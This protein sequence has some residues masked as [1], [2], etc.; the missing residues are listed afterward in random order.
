MP[1]EGDHP[2]Q[3]QGQWAPPPAPVQQEEQE[4]QGLPLGVVGLQAPLREVQ[5]QGPAPLVLGGQHQVL[6]LG[7]G[8]ELP[9]R[10]TLGPHQLRAA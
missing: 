2:H 8:V 9:R 6:P 1:L 5:E 7:R 10:L 4:E 3:A